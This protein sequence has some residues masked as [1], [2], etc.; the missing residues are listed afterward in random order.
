MNPEFVHRLCVPDEHYGKIKESLKDAGRI[1]IYLT[2]KNG[3]RVRFYKIEGVIYAD[4][5]KEDDSIFTQEV[6]KM[7]DIQKVSNDHDAFRKEMMKRLEADHPNMAQEEREAY[8][9]VLREA[10]D[11]IKKLIAGG[12]EPSLAYKIIESVLNDKEII[13]GTQ[14]GEGSAEALAEVL[15]DR[16]RMFGNPKAPGYGED[17][18][19]ESPL[20]EKI[21]APKTEEAECVHPQGV[22]IL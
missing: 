13:D 15:R 11:S 20:S 12:M 1:G 5:R 21:D 17:E 9:D 10:N 4:E 18:K 3:K 7:S 8:A 16:E 6:I 14:K 22:P 2:D 19:I